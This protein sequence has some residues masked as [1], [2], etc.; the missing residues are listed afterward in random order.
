MSTFE[1]REIAVEDGPHEGI[2]AAGGVVAAGGEEIA[3]IGGAVAADGGSMADVGAGV[4]VV[5]D[6]GARTA[7]RGVVDDGGAVAAGRAG[8]A[9]RGMGAA[10]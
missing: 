7:V 1:A 9:V 4:A 2:T 5:T 10:G 6:E 8:V 3:A